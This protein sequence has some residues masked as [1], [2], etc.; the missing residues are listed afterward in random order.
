VRRTAEQTAPTPVTDAAPTPIGA[1]KKPVLEIAMPGQ[2]LLALGLLKHDTVLVTATNDGLVRLW[3]AQSGEPRKT[4]ATMVRTGATLA[5]FPSSQWFAATDA[6]HA[7]GIYDPLGNRESVLRNDPPHPITILAVSSDDRLLAEAAESGIVNLWDVTANRRLH[8][9]APGDS[10]VR[11]LVFSPDG[12]RLL[13]GN[14]HGELIAW[15]TASGKPVNRRQLHKHSILALAVAPGGQT[16]ASQSAKGELRLS[17]MNADSEGKILDQGPAG[18]SDLAFSADGKWLLA[19][20][21]QGVRVW[22]TET[23]ELAHELPNDKRAV[24]SL[25]LSRDGKLIAVGND[26]SVR[27]WR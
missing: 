26:L 27:L 3:D 11:T 18:G 22:S 4:V 8:Q 1:D 14:A 6:D 16:V 12:L 17:S 5:V 2:A 25:A 7:I 24:R 20:S 13:A 9:F 23:G 10:A 19:G 15:E 21:A